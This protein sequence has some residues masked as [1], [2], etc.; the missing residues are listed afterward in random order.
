MPR[1]AILDTNLLLLAIVG[2]LAPHLV[3]THRRLREFGP[4]D[5]PRLNAILSDFVKFFTVPNLLSETSNWIE[6]GDRQICE[7]ATDAFSAYVA[8]TEEIYFPSE[9]AVSYPEFRR[10]GLT[11]TVLLEMSRRG[12]TTITADFALANR[13]QQLKYPCINFN[14][15]R[16]PREA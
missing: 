2:S 11:D 6:Q 7:G 15:L 9:K 10:L 3:G 1:S 12:V 14:H 5:L 16:T 4:K 13:L 8:T